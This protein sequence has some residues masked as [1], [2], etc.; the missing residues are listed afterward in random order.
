M[1]M[2]EAVFK[3]RGTDEWLTRMNAAGVPVA[4]IQPVDRVL[5][6]PQV[7]HRRMIVEVEHPV[8]G[9]LPTLGT[10]IK[11]DGQLDLEIA[12][13][14]RLGEHTDA[15]LG[16]LLCYSRERVATLHRDGVVA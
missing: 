1:A 8:H 6:D 9:A 7:R 5:A 2:I 14:A 16:E 12:P 4:P 10:P 15:V 3:E 11:V 13:P